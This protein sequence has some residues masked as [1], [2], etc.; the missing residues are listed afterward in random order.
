MKLTKF[1][2]LVSPYTMTSKI[3]IETLYNALEKIRLNN[4]LGD[5]IEVGVW[6]GG[7]ILGIIEY[8]NYYSMTDRSVWL[9]DTFAGMTKPSEKD[10]TNE[11]NKECSMNKDDT[12]SFWER[13]NNKNVNNWCYCSLDDVKK[14]LSKS[15]FPNNNI[16]YIVGDVC[17]TLK[18]K[19]NI[20]EKISL[21]RLD[22]DWYES[23]KIEL[24]YMYP[25]LSNGGVLIVDDYGYWNGSKKAVDEYFENKNIIIN[26][27]KNDDGIIINKS[28]ESSNRFD[29]K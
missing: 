24:E 19:T 4:I 21:L 9:Y 20:P 16:K 5:L 11:F 10:C 25:K 29:N 14:T 12:L 15:N 18:D 3:R 26:K 8:L 2:D 13:H 17:V 23:T 7:N 27:L 6:K 28:Y 22:T 1:I